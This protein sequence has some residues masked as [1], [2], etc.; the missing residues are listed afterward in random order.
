MYACMHACMH[1][2][3]YV[4]SLENSLHISF[5]QSRTKVVGTVGW[6]MYPP[7]P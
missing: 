4:L 6:I 1:V 5:R 2:C 7:F 3:M